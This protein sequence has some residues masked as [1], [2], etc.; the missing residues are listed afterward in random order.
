MRNPFSTWFGRRA[1]PRKSDM[2]PLVITPMPSLVSILLRLEEEK[3]EPLTEAE[4]N[5]ARDNAA[6][7]ALPADEAAA[8]ARSRGYPDIDADAAWSAWL[9]FKRQ[10][11]G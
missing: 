8:V 4:V 1:A 6:C 10:T 9:D 5:H 2:R 11:S 7:V 3:G